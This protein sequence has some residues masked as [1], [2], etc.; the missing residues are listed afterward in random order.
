MKMAQRMIDLA[1]RQLEDDESSQSQEISDSSLADHMQTNE[2]VEE[3][4]LYTNQEISDTSLLRIEEP[5][6]NQSRVTIEEAESETGIL[7]TTVQ[8]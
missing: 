7:C 8:L 6:N 1:K 5:T 2:E 4:N 3:E